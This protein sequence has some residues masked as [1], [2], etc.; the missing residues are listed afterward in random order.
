MLEIVNYRYF[1]NI[2]NDVL[3]G[4]VIK[5]TTALLPYLLW[6]SPLTFLREEA[7]GPGGPDGGV[8]GVGGGKV[9]PKAVTCSCE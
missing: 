7:T 4:F 8:G 2:G 9:H 5:V 6:R 3:S 1:L